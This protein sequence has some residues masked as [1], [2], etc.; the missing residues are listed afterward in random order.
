MNFEKTLNTVNKFFNKKIKIKGSLIKKC[1]NM[2][3]G[4]ALEALE[5]GKRVSRE[6][7]IS[8]DV[9]LFLVPGTKF[10]VNSIPIMEGYPEKTE[11]SYHARVDMKSAHGEVIPWTCLQTD[12]FAKDWCVV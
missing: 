8:K 1:K 10:K 12:M 3:F 2:T 5:S 7:W 6:E 4:E 9:F 11:F